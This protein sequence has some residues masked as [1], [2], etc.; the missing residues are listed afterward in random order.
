MDEQ[1]TVTNNTA[2]TDEQQPKHPLSETNMI[3]KAFEDVMANIVK[4][5]VKSSMKASSTP[6]T[7]KKKINNSQPS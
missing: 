4:K 5:Y 1:I 7:M 2:N 6:K 3:Q